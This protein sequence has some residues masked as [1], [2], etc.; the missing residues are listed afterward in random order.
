MTARALFWAAL[1][2]YEAAVVVYFIRAALAK[3]RRAKK[4][5]TL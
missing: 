3:R 1:A 2:V 4:G 5:A